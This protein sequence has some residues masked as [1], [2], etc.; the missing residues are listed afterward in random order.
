MTSRRS[1]AGN[2]LLVAL[3]MLAILSAVGA[4]VLLSVTSRYQHTQKAVGWSEA[5]NAA[6]AGVDDA[7]ANCRRTITNAAAW[8]NWKKYNT[9]TSSWVTVTSASDANAELAA[10]RKIIYDLPAGSHLISSGEGT[11]DLWYHVEV[12]IPRSLLVV[13]ETAGIASA[14]PDTP[15]CPGWRGQTTRA[16]TEI[17]NHNSKLRKIDL[18]IDHFIKRYGNYQHAAGTTVAVTPQATRRLEV[19]VQPKTPFGM[20]MVATAPT[21]TAIN[22]PLI[23]SF[24]STDLVNYPGG[25]YNSGARDPTTG[26]GSRAIVYVTSPIATFSAKLYGDLRTNGGGVKKGNNITGTV[27]NNITIDVPPVTTPTL[28]ATASSAA[29]SIMVAGTTAS[30]SYATYSSING[31]IV[32]PPLGQTTGVANLYI[33]GNV[34]GGITVM[35]GVTLKI[36]FAGN[37]SMKS[38]DIDNLNFKAANLQLYGIDPINGQS[39]SFTLGSGNPGVSYFTL[40][41]PSYDF[42]SNGNVDVAGAVIAKTILGN[43]NTSWHYDESLATAG[44]VL[45]YQRASWVEDPRYPEPPKKTLPPVKEYFPRKA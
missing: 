4:N 29:P 28:A 35:P 7:F 13:L 16:S 37:F 3:G 33:T 32:T 23:D 14:P 40:N 19:I 36:W 11:N 1:E 27:T 17:S 38:R 6:E 2:T 18:R 42:S 10:G 30:P 41:A 43:G 12:D 45:D 24:D 21:G 15:P 9:G 20:A 39:R 25:L 26:V 8:T 31:I 22:A 34:T 5:L 44:E